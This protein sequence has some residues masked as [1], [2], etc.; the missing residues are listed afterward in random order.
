[1][2][3]GPGGA[4]ALN[5]PPGSL[6]MASALDAPRTPFWSAAAQAFAKRPAGTGALFGPTLSLG[7]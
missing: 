4:L 2:G 7:H 5:G 3:E 1:L 6:G